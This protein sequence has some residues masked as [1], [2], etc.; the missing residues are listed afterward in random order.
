MSTVTTSCMI[1]YVYTHTCTAQL[2]STYTAKTSDQN[3][4]G[5]VS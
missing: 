2:K 1:L 3:N 5:M 4:K